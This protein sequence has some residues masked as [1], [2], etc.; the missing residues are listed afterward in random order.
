MAELLFKKF[1]EGCK[2]TNRCRAQDGI[3]R[4][5]RGGSGKRSTIARQH[6][7][8][9]GSEGEG[10]RHRTARQRRRFRQAREGQLE[11]RFVS[12]RR[13]T[14]WLVQPGT[15]VL[16][17]VPFSSD[18]AKQPR[19]PA[20]Y[21]GCAGQVG[22]SA[23][24][25][26]KLEESAQP[27]RLRSTRSRASSAPLV[28]QKQFE[29]QRPQ[30]PGEDGEGRTLALDLFR[31]PGS[32]SSRSVV[33]RLDHWRVNARLH[34]PSCHV[35]VHGQQRIIAE[36]QRLRLRCSVSCAASPGPTSASGRL[37]QFLVVGAD[38][39]SEILRACSSSSCRGRPRRRCS[40][41]SS[42]RVTTSALRGIGT[43][44]EIRLEFHL[45]AMSSVSTPSASFH[46]AATAIQTFFD[47]HVLVPE[48][49]RAAAATTNNPTPHKACAPLQRDQWPLS[50]RQA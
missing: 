17:K 4:T 2:A 37:Q 43:G 8:R 21:N 6:P 48:H 18:A 46:I 30:G 44:S 3:R 15:R 22:V 20:S 14:F 11:G 28:Q 49:E 7:R 25:V 10:I 5:H 19:D 24:H 38:P 39:V 45:P 23:E 50:L 13:R 1:T 12:G 16:V 27:R 47:Q 34:Q 32:T 26:I 40:R 29:T 33:H 31:E 9:R 35:V 36:H 42:Q 41:R